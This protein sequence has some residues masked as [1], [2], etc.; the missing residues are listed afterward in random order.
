MLQL[1]ESLNNVYQFS[2]LVESTDTWGGFWLSEA[3]EISVWLYANRH[4]CTNW[5][6]RVT[7]C[8][9]LPR[10]GWVDSQQL[11]WSCGASDMS[12]VSAAVT[13]FLQSS[14]IMH[15]SSSCVGLISCMAGVHEVFVTTKFLKLIKRAKR[16]DRNRTNVSNIDVWVAVLPANQDSVI[17]QTPNKHCMLEPIPTWLAKAL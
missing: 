4:D 17:R 8:W 10:Q 7:V 16:A 5:H 14:P 11:G 15:K 9:L 2:R 6:F 3:V 1:K 12:A 13:Y